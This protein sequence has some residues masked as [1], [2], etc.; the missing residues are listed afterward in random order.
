MTYM[1]SFIVDIDLS[2]IGLCIGY[3]AVL[4]LS[5]SLGNSEIANYNA[6][7]IVCPPRLNVG[8][9]T[10]ISVDNIDQSTSSVTATS[11]LHGTA[12]SVTQHPMDSDIIN[13][14]E[15]LKVKK[16]SNTKLDDLPDYYTS[17][18]EV[19]IIKDRILISKE[20]RLPEEHI[21]VLNKLDNIEGTSRVQNLDED[22]RNQQKVHWAASHAS[23]NN[24][25]P[26]EK[27]LSAVLPLFQ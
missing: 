11:D 22:D 24:R 17:V 2:E 19:M 8:L 20:N 15:V 3:K 14:Q 21:D 4:E 6:K 13:D 5:T 7:N 27:V 26:T 10:T 1:V 9:V 12:I 18:P 23:Q 16:C 25:L